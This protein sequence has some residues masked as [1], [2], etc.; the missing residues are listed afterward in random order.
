MLVGHGNL[1]NTV[2]FERTGVLIPGH[3]NRKMSPNSLNRKLKSSTLFF[4]AKNRCSAHCI[5]EGGETLVTG[6]KMQHIKKE[7]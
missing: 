6:V 1:A 7:N 5:R 4:T 2:G 3:L